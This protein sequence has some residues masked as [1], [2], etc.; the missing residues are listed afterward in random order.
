MDNQQLEIGFWQNIPSSKKYR[1]SLY[2]KLKKII[3]SM[4]ESL[5]N[6]G[7]YALIIDIITSDDCPYY[8]NFFI[9]AQNIDKTYNIWERH[10]CTKDDTSFLEWIQETPYYNMFKHYEYINSIV[11]WDNDTQEMQRTRE[12]CRLLE[13]QI[14][15]FIGNV[16]MKE[17]VLLVK[18]LFA[19]NVI[20]KKFGKN[21]QFVVSEYT[22]NFDNVFVTK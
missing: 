5:I 15:E 4:D 13:G 1:D 14:E 20:E 9:T 10:I 6:K 18:E 21:V 11:D 8:P 3:E 2:C 16:F 17:I 22:G 12:L 19:E 7:I